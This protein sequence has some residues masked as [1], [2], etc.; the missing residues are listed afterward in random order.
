[1]SAIEHIPEFSRPID[2]GLLRFLTCGSEMTTAR[3]P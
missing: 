1:M 3:A 2:N